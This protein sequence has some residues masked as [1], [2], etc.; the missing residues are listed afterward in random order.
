MATANRHRR[1]TRWTDT[2][3]LR[4][5]DIAVVN[6]RAIY[7]ILGKQYR[8][9]DLKRLLACGLSILAIREER[10]KGKLEQAQVGGINI[11]IKGPDSRLDNEFHYTG[12]AD[13][14]LQCKVHRRR[15]ETKRRCLTCNVP[16]C[17]DD[18]WARYH[19][20]ADF[21]I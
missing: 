6:V 15:C 16:L 21:K 9:V 13:S 20:L 3:A 18:A 17:N 4:L 5:L 14:R 10:F 7:K 8:M 19:T 12:T 1:T 11:K 2:V